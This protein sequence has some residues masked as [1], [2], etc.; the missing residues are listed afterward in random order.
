MENILYNISQVL[1]ITIINSL[2]QG[3]LIYFMLRL[4]LM[5]SSQLSSSKKYMLAL[6]S[7]AAITCWFVYTLVNEIHIYNWLAVTP[8]K[9]SAMPLMLELP[10]NVHRFNDQTIRYYYS[11]EE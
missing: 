6:T 4:A 11:I 2:W 3:L 5:F 9:L 1:G 8:E 7:L 10:M